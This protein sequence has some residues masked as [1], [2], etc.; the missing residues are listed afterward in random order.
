[1]LYRLYL[2]TS[3]FGA[4]FDVE[5]ARRVAVTKRLLR[6][7]RRPPFEAF[8]G[9]PLYEEV[10]RAPETIRAGLEIAIRRLRPTVI[11]EDDSSLSLAEAYVRAGVVGQRHR[12][13]A[14][15]PAPCPLA[16]VDT[17]VSWNFRHMVNVEKKRLVHSV[18]ARL[19]HHLI[20]IVSPL[21]VADV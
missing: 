21:E 18:N 5:D 17:V 14:G 9:I 2:D 16:R 8:V 11:E 10:A 3:V 15:H 6:R 20:D 12:G 7:A 1:M 4:L 13:D 19:G